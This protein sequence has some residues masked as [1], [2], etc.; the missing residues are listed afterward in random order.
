MR[1]LATFRRVVS[2]LL[3]IALL[4][5]QA[6]AMTAVG[7]LGV[8][9]VGQQNLSFWLYASGWEKTAATL[10]LL[11]TGQQ[12]NSAGNT[13]ETQA[14]RDARVARIK[15][16]PDNVM[17]QTGQRVILQAI[18]YD[19]ADNA[20]AGVKY[21]WSANDE[22]RK[23]P[24]QVSPQGEFIS[25]IDGTFKVT[26]YGAGHAAHV[27]IKVVGEPFKPKPKEAIPTGTV[28]TRDVPSATSDT[29]LNRG[30]SQRSFQRG[31]VAETAPQTVKRNLATRRNARSF[32]TAAGAL[33]TTSAF[34]L[35]GD[36]YGWT[37]NNYMTADDCG[38][39]VGD[40]PGH[41]QDDGAGSGNH[42]FTAPILN[43]EGRGLDLTL[44]AAYN[45][46][47]WHKAGNEIT[48]DIDRDWPAPGFS[49]GFGKITQTGLSHGFMLI[50]GDGT[51]HGFNCS[52][53]GSGMQCY[54]ID[55]TFIDYEVATSPYPVANTPISAIAK[56]PDGTTITYGAPAT[57]AVYPTKIMDRNGNYITISY[58]NDQG[59]R[60]AAI[61]DTLGRIINFHYDSSDPSNLLLT[62]IT[63]QDFSTGASRTLARFNY[64]NLTLS[65]GYTS[66]PTPKVRASSFKMIKAIYYPA[67]A[68]GY[69]FGDSGSYSS[70]GMLLKVCEQ[71]G[72]GF[73]NSTALTSQGTITAGTMSHE[74]TYIYNSPTTVEPTYTEMR[75][76]WAG[77]ETSAGTP[78]YDAVTGSAQTTYQVVE[79]TSASRRYT[80]IVRPDGTI[81]VQWQ[82]V[83]PNQFY[84]GLLL[85]E[86]VC[87][88][89]TNCGYNDGGL[90]ASSTDWEL[91]TAAA[92]ASYNSPRPA[93]VY[94]QPRPWT[95]VQFTAGNYVKTCY[96]Y[97]PYNRPTRI[98]EF[99]Y[100]AAIRSTEI[101]YETN[102][103]YDVSRHIFRLPKIVEVKEDPDNANITK[104]K[105]EYVYDYYSQLSDT[106]NV[107]QHDAACD[108]QNPYYDS[109]T[110]YRGLVTQIKRYPTPSSTAGM[111]TE[112]RTYDQTGNLL[113]AAT[114]CCE[115]TSFTYAQATQ[116]AYPITQKRGSASDP[117]T[118]I[119][120][121][122]G[123]DYYTGLVTQT[124][125]ANGRTS[126]TTYCTTGVNCTLNPSYTPP[127]G[128]PG[129]LR[130]KAENS[131]T[132]A[133][134]EYCY[135]DATLQIKTTAYLQNGTTIGSQTLKTLDGVGRIRNEIAYGAAMVQDIVD[136]RYDGLG[137]VWKQTRPYRTSGTEQWYENFY[138]PLDRLTKV[139]STINGQVETLVEK[140]Y[141]DAAPAPSVA[142]AA[143]KGNTICTKDAWGRE[144]W[145]RFDWA[146]RLCEVVEP[147]AAGTGSVATGGTLTKY[148]YDVL[149]NLTQ[150]DQNVVSGVA[151]QTRK[152]KYDGL[153]RLTHQKLAE[154][155]CTLSDAGAH[156]GTAAGVWS[157]VFTYD[158]RSN[159]T[160]HT[161]ARGVK[162]N[163]TYNSDPL[164]RLQSVSYDK[165]TAPTAANII[166]AATVTYEY[167]TAGDRTR[168]KKIID[169]AGTDEFAYDP[170]GRLCETKRTFTNR[171]GQPLQ[172]NYLYDTLDRLEKTIYPAEYSSGTIRKEVLAEFDEAS[173]FKTLKYDNKNFASAITYNAASQTTALTVGHTVAPNNT[174]WNETYTYE[175]ATGLLTNQKVQLVGGATPALDLSY[176]YLKYNTT[177]GRTGQL[178]KIVNNKDLTKNKY[179]DYDALGRLKTLYSFT[180]GSNP[181]TNYQW[182]QGY[183]Y[184]R[185]GNR[186]GVTMAGSIGYTDGLTALSFTD[187]AG[188]VRTNRITTAGYTYD[189][190]GNQ[191]CGQ[192]EGGVWQKYKYDVAGRL[193]QTLT[194]DP[195]P[196]L[197]ADYCYGA[198]NHRLKQIE[199]GSGGTTYYYAW[200]GNSIIAEYSD[201]GSA[202]SWAKSYVY[203]GGRLL[204]TQQSGNLTNY[205]HPD[206]LGTRLVTSDTG[207]SVVAEQ[208]TLPY[209][210]ALDGE[211]WGSTTNRRFTSYDRSQKTKLDYAVN[212][213]YNACQ[214]RFTQV[215]P[216]GM[217]AVEFEDP[218][219]LNLYAYVGNDPIN[220][221]DPDGLFFKRLFGAIKKFFSKL[222]VRIAVLVALVIITAGAAAGY[223]SLI[224]KVAI[225][226]VGVP[227]NGGLSVLGWIAAGLSAVSGVSLPGWFGAYGGFR[228]PGING[229]SSS[230]FTQGNRSRGNQG[231]SALD[232]LVRGAEGYFDRIEHQMLV[233]TFNVV[234]D[235]LSRP[236][237]ARLLGGVEN[238]QRLLSRVLPL[239]SNTLS[240]NFR[241]PWAQVAR[242]DAINPR[243]RYAAINPVRGRLMYIADRFFI[244]SWKDQASVVIHELKHANGFPGE[245]PGYDYAADIRR[246]KINCGLL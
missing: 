208:T 87:A 64:S 11:L 243:G 98:V 238:A 237:C 121:S 52:W 164:N 122:A 36:P 124:T 29:S 43:L 150:V 183:S 10:P 46:R 163:F 171:A 191:T 141:D 133:K 204:A 225:P 147:D 54:T 12:A 41:P 32:K 7:F 118:Q 175:A 28:S 62:A 140:K 5:N 210:R 242:R 207:G 113:T 230:G 67:T 102:S 16:S 178:T 92:P 26:A 138:D 50:D 215:D 196:V 76:K 209:G 167:M 160:C 213:F 79:E 83:A 216:I 240:P 236:L 107:V 231:A 244:Q 44:A 128:T 151:E 78:G 90:R 59:P 149:N 188:K 197:L 86:K 156:V 1:S 40:P 120:T 108:P 94:V 45:G 20:V 6:F 96:F 15:I 206:R 142:D 23:E 105:T 89:G 246:I 144:R 201:T 61:T 84:D 103:A 99:S 172:V 77:M 146:D 145:A 202:L 104:Q 195:T 48:F 245:R 33:T 42:Q 13:P 143:G 39:E 100:T 35:W 56:L 82:H 185:F 200:D 198:S 9:Q 58:V 3:T 159:L 184:D 205:H 18:A 161:D 95:G 158:L 222:I 137:R 112:T 4:A 25:L 85:L 132:G 8:W 109:M 219:T 194:N 111:V 233:D 22:G 72:M 211:S 189:E 93:A 182:M 186:T 174:Q 51:R 127:S 165:T 193:A 119:T 37:D 66:N 134:V 70:Y 63:A 173:R 232:R 73:D 187:G 176:E 24:A 19:F 203:L 169:G 227:A 239:N 14:E 226:G 91:Y 166:D 130:P 153:S 152:F 179:Y 162:T 80:R 241:G 68:T 116:Y 110:D 177:F 30:Q 155:D 148:S 139:C 106:P 74:M 154:R 34:Q 234:K 214:G 181:M 88:P 71:R 235:R 69:W 217:Q 101:Q 117:N 47:T 157:D 21:T 212:R 135:D 49:L 136:T 229:N 190:A 115:Q 199:Y 114:S 131:P 192:T 221:I 60:I 228:T 223:W 168:L 31:Q 38:K 126:T 2:L 97:G 129:T 220:N 65:Y 27:I 125:D 218:Q 81:Q 55:G 17:A 170:E 224:V 53:N 180:N 123:Y 75:E 57:Y